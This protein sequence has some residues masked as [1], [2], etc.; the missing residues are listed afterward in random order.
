MWIKFKTRFYFQRLSDKKRNGIESIEAEDM[1]QKVEELA[2]RLDKFE[3]ELKPLN[4][5]L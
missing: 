1:N 3:L 5:K 4:G 2:A